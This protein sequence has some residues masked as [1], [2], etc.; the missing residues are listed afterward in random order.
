MQG[1]EAVNSM[2]EIAEDLESENDVS[3]GSHT[4]NKKKKTDELFGDEALNE[5]FSSSI[6]KVAT[7]KN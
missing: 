5:G 3:V 7:A 1:S 2:S 4:Y 6:V